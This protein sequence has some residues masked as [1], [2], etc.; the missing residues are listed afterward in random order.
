MTSDCASELMIDRMIAGELAAEAAAGIR[1]HAATC[2][3]CG[4]LVASAESARRRFAAAPPPLRL[5]GRRARVAGAAAA[6][7]AL[8]VALVAVWRAGPDG[9]RT[10]GG[11]SLGVFVSH[12]GVLRRGGAGEVV[13]PGDRLQLVT[14][15]DRAGW[16][17][18]TALDGRGARTVYA[19][20][21]PVG[22][23]RDRPLPFSIVLDDALGPTT[24]T[25]VFCA[26]SFALEAPPPG[27]TR[28][29]IRLEVR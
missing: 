12:H 17:A 5:P 10:K 27:C 7:A 9:V 1:G 22:A 25:A 14:A 26:E 4:E 24:I 28:D 21:R 6:A 20:P 8:A 3:S 15:T 18:I 23:G 19:A 16:I 13:A 11:A 29:A 2:A